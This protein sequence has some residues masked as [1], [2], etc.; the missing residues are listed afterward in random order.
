[1]TACTITSLPSSSMTGRVTAQ[2]H[3]QPV[4]R[5]P[6]P[7]KREDVVVVERGGPDRDDRPAVGN[8]GFGPFPD[9][10][11]GQRVVG[12]DRLCVDGKHPGSLATT[13]WLHLGRPDRLEPRRTGQSRTS[14]RATTSS[15]G[16]A[17]TCPESTPISGVVALDPPAV[18]DAA[19]QPFDGSG[20]PGSRMTASRPGRGRAP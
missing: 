18:V 11:P 15:S 20:R 14:T 8:L 10:Q 9:D 17:P 4:R 3:R 19:H 12:V 1:M 16:M 5:Q 2:D 6:D 7:A 13:T